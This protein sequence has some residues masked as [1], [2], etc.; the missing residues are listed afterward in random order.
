MLISDTGKLCREHW[1]I[2]YCYCVVFVNDCG[3]M[4]AFKIP[5]LNGSVWRKQNGPRLGDP[6]S[7][8]VEDYG[9]PSSVLG[10]LKLQRTLERVEKVCSSSDK[11]TFEHKFIV[12]ELY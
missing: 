11:T 8:S 3:M 7:Y 12:L 6:F 2:L 10:R 4:F 5:D 1:S 9:I